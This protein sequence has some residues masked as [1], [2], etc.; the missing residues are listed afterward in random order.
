[1]SAGPRNDGIRNDGVPDDG[2]AQRQPVAGQLPP[3]APAR[4]KE[5]GTPDIPAPSVLFVCVHNA[6]RSQMAAAFLTHLAGDRI[7]VRSAGSDPADTVH[8][9]VVAAMAEAGIDISAE[10]PEMLTAEA[11]RTSDVVITMGCGDAC[12]GLPGTRYLDWQFPDPAGRN[13]DAVRPIRD[14]I[15]KRVRSLV[16]ELLP[17]PTGRGPAEVRVLPM[18]RQHAHEVLAVYQRGIDEGDATFETAAP[19]W[20]RFDAGKLP[21]HRYVAVDGTGRV[22]GWIAVAPVSDRQVY[23]GVVEHS[24]YVHPDARGRGIATQLLDRLV[25]STEAA[26][27]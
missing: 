13:V 16:D 6:G 15:E 7:R 14:E 3:T 23:A 12:P 21:D 8:P 4:E 18:A 9:A 19:A 11:V 24:V 22:L 27:I 25:A 20:E 26:G 5:P 1:V 10:A 2:S 17:G